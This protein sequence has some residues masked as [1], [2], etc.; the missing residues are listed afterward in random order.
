MLLNPFNLSS[1]CRTV[2]ESAVLYSKEW[3]QRAENLQL[4]TMD[5]QKLFLKVTFVAV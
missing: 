2:L 3:L 4:M 1:L 5:E